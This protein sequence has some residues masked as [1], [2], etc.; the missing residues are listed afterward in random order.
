MNGEVIRLTTLL[1][2]GIK[3][4]SRITDTV[5]VGLSTG[6]DSIVTYDLCNKY[7]KRVVPYF[8]YLVPGLEFQERTLRYYERRY[9][10]EVI[11][12]PHFETSNF[13]RY[14]TFR[15]PDESVELVSVTDEYDYLRQ[16]ADTYWIAGGERISDSIV[17]RAM[18]KNSGSVDDKRGRFYPLAHWKKADVLKYIKLNKLYLSPDNKKL[19]FSFRSLAGEEL[20]L[21]ERFYPNDYQKILHYYP[22]AGAAVE[23]FKQYGK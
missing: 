1:F 21:V 12:I 19:G 4:M 6:K 8:M 14:G 22:L 7:F 23:R 10:N 5:L 2:D 15:G 3:T 9:G 17:R 20:A 18:L 13:Y 11:R 16:R